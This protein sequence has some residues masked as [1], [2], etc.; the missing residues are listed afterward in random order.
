ME[1]GRPYVV[2]YGLW[3]VALGMFS[4]T[5]FFA[6][7]IVPGYAILIAAGFLAAAGE[8]NF[9]LVSIVAC[10]SSFLG[11]MCSYGLGRWYGG[12]LLRRHARFTTRVR[13]ALETEGPILL[14]MYH[15]AHP[16]R[17]LLP[18]TAGYS[19]Y[20]IRTWLTY[21][22]IGILIWVNLIAAIGYTANRAI[23]SNGGVISLAFD[24]LATLVMIVVTWRLYRNYSLAAKSPAFESPPVST[25]VEEKED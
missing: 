9:A 25:D 22:A 3:A 4:E 13:V 1:G 14:L 20:P 7:F 19:R 16:L 11:D 5:F 12:Y 17:A 8:I 2:K 21:D 10:T 15:Y 6:G 23:F 18:C 24:T